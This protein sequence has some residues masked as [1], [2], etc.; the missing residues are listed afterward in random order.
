MSSRWK[1]FSRVRCDAKKSHIHLSN[2]NFHNCLQRRIP[3]AL[4]TLPSAIYT[5]WCSGNKTCRG[6]TRRHFHIHIHLSNDNLHDWYGKQ[7]IQKA[8]CVAPQKGFTTSVLVWVRVQECPFVNQVVDG[9]GKSESTVFVEGP[10][11]EVCVWCVATGAGLKVTGAGQ[12]LALGTDS[13]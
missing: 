10:A 2:V 13:S 6:S 1:L 11:P 3:S 8:V 9:D 12:Q 7:E 5:L 4:H